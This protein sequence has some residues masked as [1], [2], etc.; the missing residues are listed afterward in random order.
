MS[1]NFST[2][3][4]DQFR[5]TVCKDAAEIVGAFSSMNEDDLNSAVLAAFLASAAGNEAHDDDIKKVLSWASGIQFQAVTLHFVLIGAMDVTVIDGQLH[6]RMAQGSPD[7]M[8]R[9]L[10]RHGVAKPSAESAT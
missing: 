1:K 7:E 2:E 5:D 4:M 8:M 10:V 6:F 9:Q 3:E